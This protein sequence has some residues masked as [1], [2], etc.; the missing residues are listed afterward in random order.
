MIRDQ[1]TADDRI[2]DALWFL[3]GFAAAA[4]SDSAETAGDLARALNEV[5]QWINAISSG[6]LRL[7]GTDERNFYIVLAEH[8]Y[9]KLIDGLR[10]GVGAEDHAIAVALNSRIVEQ[11]R[12]EQKAFVNRRVGEVP[13]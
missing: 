8:E 3:K 5:R 2:A 9:E 6:D 1:Q 11:F 12:A 4:N 10:S 13:F 7:I